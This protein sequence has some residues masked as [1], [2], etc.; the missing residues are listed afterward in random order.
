MGTSAYSAGI[1][2]SEGAAKPAFA[3]AGTSGAPVH[4]RTAS[5]IKRHYGKG[6]TSGRASDDAKSNDVR[7]VMEDNKRML[8]ERGEKLRQ[9]DEKAGEL[10]EGASNFAAMA[11]QLRD[12][13][14]KRA[15]KWW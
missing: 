13:Q 10:E 9:L 4:L 5:E 7:G 2:G 6:G 11:K 3:G 8:A 15:G 12:Q 1:G 14:E